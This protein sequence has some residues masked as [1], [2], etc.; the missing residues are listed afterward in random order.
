M[1]WQFRFVLEKNIACPKE[2]EAGGA[3]ITC[4]EPN[5]EVL[6]S[7]VYRD[8]NKALRQVSD[9]S[10]IHRFIFT[11][12]P[13]V[14]RRWRYW[15]EYRSFWLMDVDES[16]LPSNKNVTKVCEY[17]LINLPRPNPLLLNGDPLVYC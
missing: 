8:D 10:F 3:L 6:G 9:H 16:L 7:E 11:T 14:E 2:N 1:P 15:G 17:I 13:S 12:G 4:L 5:S